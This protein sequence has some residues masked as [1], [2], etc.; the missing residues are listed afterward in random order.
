[1]S[2]EQSRLEAAGC[3][4]DDV[5]K[6]TLYLKDIAHLPEVYKVMAEYFPNAEAYPACACIQA[7]E[8]AHPDYMLEIE[9]VAAI[10]H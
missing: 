9:V 5:V 7:A 4:M 8:L 6:R 1:M 3:T 10:E 2:N